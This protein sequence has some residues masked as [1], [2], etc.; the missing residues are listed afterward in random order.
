MT[1]PLQKFHILATEACLAVLEQ[2]VRGGGVVQDNLEHVGTEEV[3]HS[4]GE[5]DIVG[6]VGIVGTVAIAPIV[7][8]VATIAVVAINV[9]VGDVLRG[10]WY[11][12]GH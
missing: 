3:G 5:F 10:A 12:R 7:D 9:A 1:Y 8:I 4:R 11:W 2:L 6:I